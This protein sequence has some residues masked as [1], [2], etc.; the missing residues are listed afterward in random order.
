[1]RE[2]L[3]GFK[4]I[5]MMIMNASQSRFFNLKSIMILSA[6]FFQGHRWPWRTLFFVSLLLLGCDS[7]PKVIVADESLGS[8]S[9]EEGSLPV[10]K[11]IARR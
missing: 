10:F 4:N 7:G 8:Q 2:L 1:M 6:S 9:I 3:N 11:D 5:I